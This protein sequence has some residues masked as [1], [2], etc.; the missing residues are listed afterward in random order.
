MIF[1]FIKGD[2]KVIHSWG[3]GDGIMNIQ[4]L[5]IGQGKADVV[6]SNFWDILGSD[7][8]RVNNSLD[9]KHTY[10]YRVVYIIYIFEFL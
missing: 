8:A 10:V 5:V 3:E 2:G 9:W 1:L 4:Q 6:E 7:T